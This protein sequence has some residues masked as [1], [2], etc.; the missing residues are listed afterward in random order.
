MNIRARMAEKTANLRSTAEIEA[1]D[2]PHKVAPR[3][4]P[5]MAAALAS[6]Q[7]R[8]QELE[9]KGVEM[10]AVVAE[11]SPNPWQPRKVFSP[12]KMTELAES[13]RE[14]GLMQPILVRRTAK[15]DQIIA[16]ERRWRAHQVLQLPKIR[17]IVTE[18]SDEDMVIFALVENVA[19]DDLSDFEIGMSLRRS[20][21]E[22][23]NR[24]RLQ[25]ALGLS[26]TGLYQFLSFEKLPEFMLAD[27]NVNPRLLGGNA[28]DA[29][30][31]ALR[32][33]G[34]PGIEAAKSVWPL[35]VRGRLEQ[36]KVANAIK[37][38]ATRRASAP[39]ASTG[40]TIDKFFAGKEHAGSITKD[41]NSFT[42]KI[43]DG[44]LTEAQEEQIRALISG[45]F[46]SQPK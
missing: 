20:E 15:G 37:A 19:R 38:L 3:T 2:V 36:G 30:V 41:V 34:E 32:K 45:M 7:L 13:I 28:A 10:D 35:L 27:L 9:S 18:C 43:K 12:E 31:S 23:P 14:I 4:A 44:Y 42:I 26:R 17:A 16:G 46:A 40:R 1:K 8:I 25:E 11:L 6:A 24:K 22:F 39:G 21:K 5:G 29:I 33:L